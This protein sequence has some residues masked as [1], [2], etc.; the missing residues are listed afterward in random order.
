MRKFSDIFIQET[1]ITEA[2]YLELQTAFC[3]SKL[4][5]IILYLNKELLPQIITIP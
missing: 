1:E 4:D 5:K 3:F 2:V